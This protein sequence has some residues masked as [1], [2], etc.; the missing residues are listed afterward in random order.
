MHRLNPAPALA[1]APIVA[2]VVARMM[3]AAASPML[4]P[5]LALAPVLAL[6]PILALAP[7][8]ALTLPS[9]PAHAQTIRGAGARPCTEW[10]QAR[11]GNGRDF[12]A[13]QWALGYLSAVSAATP[14]RGV[15]RA[16]DQKT[17]FAGMDTYCGAH[18]QD[19]LW[20]AVKSV[21][22]VQHG[23]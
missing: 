1:A 15:L 7:V 13:E 14:E 11:T 10:L 19:M 8:L 21:L 17:I 4:A 2:C 18:R 16:A 23:A 12:E 22:A 3:A 5:I 6:A 9:A 20:N